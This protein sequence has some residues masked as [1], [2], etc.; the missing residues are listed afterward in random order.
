SRGL[1]PL[2]DSCPAGPARDGP[3]S[4]HLLP[5]AAVVLRVARDDDLPARLPRAGVLVIPAPVPP[6]GELLA[7]QGLDGV[8][9]GLLADATDLEAVD[10]V[11][12]VDRAE[13]GQPGEAVV[14][15]H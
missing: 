2:L 6:R 11:Q 14:G 12:Q 8:G 9:V 4:T 3:A 1:S 10:V 5:P 13:V 15:E 7:E